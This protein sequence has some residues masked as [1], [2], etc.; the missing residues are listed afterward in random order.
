MSRE[1][2]PAAGSRRG[3][4]AWISALVVLV[5]VASFFV[6]RASAPDPPVPPPVGVRLVDGVPQGWPPTPRGAGD[7]AAAYLTVLAAAAVQPREQVR[8]LL[9]RMVVSEQA[10][11]VME[12]LMPSTVGQGNPNLSQSV[13]A[14]V[15]AGPAANA[16]VSVSDGAQVTVKAL[17]CTL[18]GPVVD[19]VLAG[20]DTGLAGGWYVQTVTMSRTGGL[21][22]LVQVQVPVPVPPP[23]VRGAVRDGGPRDTQPLL[24]VLGPASWVPGTS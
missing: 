8:G 14:R 18:S 19:G 3:T 1:Y 22:L 2:K 20:P 21:W 7:T 4:A 23:D 16:E 6:G 10:E 15:W 5:A 9:Q 12:S 13:V 11:A 17:V 24:E